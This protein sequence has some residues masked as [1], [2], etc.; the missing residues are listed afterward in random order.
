MLD[1]LVERLV[2]KDAAEFASRISGSSVFAEDFEARGPMDGAG[3]SLRQL[4]LDRRLFRYP[5]SYLIYTN[6]FTS[7]PA[8]AKDYVY[9]QLSAYLGGEDRIAGDGRYALADRRAALEILKETE[10]A[11]ASY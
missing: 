4:D 3:R 10:P 9:L 6:D 1:R 8:Y 2:F 5:L 7:L 11:F